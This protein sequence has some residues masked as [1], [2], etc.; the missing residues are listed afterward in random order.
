MDSVCGT[1]RGG[2]IDRVWA[3]HAG[4]RDL[5]PHRLKPMTDQIDTCQFL[6]WRSVSMGL[7]CSVP[8]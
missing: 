7:V 4:D 5:V 6:A 2:Q 1:G 8:G 3:S